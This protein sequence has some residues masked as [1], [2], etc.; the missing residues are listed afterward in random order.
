MKE[1]FPINGEGF[2]LWESSRYRWEDEDYEPLDDEI[3]TAVPKDV[4]FIQPRWDGEAW[5]EG[6]TPAKTDASGD[7]P[8]FLT[9][10]ELAEKVIGLEDLLN[11]LTGVKA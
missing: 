10:N 6:G 11:A 3:D 8:V 7:A 4:R 9:N 5:V 2:V 1:I